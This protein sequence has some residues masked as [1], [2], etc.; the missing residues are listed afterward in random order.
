[1]GDAE[2]EEIKQ[3]IRKQ[4]RFADLVGAELL[5]V[6]PG[7]AVAELEVTSDH[8]NGVGT[9]HGGALFTLADFAFA[10]ASNSHGTVALGVQ[11]S[12]SYF[13]AVETGT[14]TARAEEIS[15]HPKLAT[16]RVEIT[17]E[18]DDLVASFE[19]TVYRKS[20]QVLEENSSPDE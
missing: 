19:G 18:T 13:K 20:D 11:S 12:I 2:P 5:E 6:T 7:S 8:H 16:Y 17:D 15:K 4:D 3:H 10:A 1:M 9:V 14:L